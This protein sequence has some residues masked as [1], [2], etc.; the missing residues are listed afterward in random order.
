M[1]VML[2]VVSSPI[3]GQDSYLFEVFEK[4]GIKYIFSELTIQPFDVGI[5]CGFAWLDILDF[6]FP[7]AEVLK[8]FCNEFGTIV[9]P[10]MLG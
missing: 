8:S 2:I 3:F 1:G 4:V 10:N 9:Y 6:H 5:L 7:F